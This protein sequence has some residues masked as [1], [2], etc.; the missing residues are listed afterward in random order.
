MVSEFERKLESPLGTLTLRS[1]GHALIRIGFPGE[2]L[3]DVAAAAG[4]ADSPL[5]LATASAQL[6]EY[7]AGKRRE[8]DLPL[9][10]AGTPFQQRV[11]A[12][13]RRIPLGETTTYA[14]LARRVGNPRACRAVGAANGQNP[15]PI[16]VPCHRVI[17][18]NGQLTGFAGGL[19]AK[20][21]LLRH[22]GVALRHS[23]PA[24]AAP[25][26]Q[27]RSGQ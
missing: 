11:W 15:L 21:W 1:D 24:T 9:A 16:V 5:V 2:E 6:R 20:A 13:L 26:A 12:E 18:S 22:E 8:F 27:T 3:E 7:F 23:C 19:P 17:G 4:N 14:T 10:A 25:T